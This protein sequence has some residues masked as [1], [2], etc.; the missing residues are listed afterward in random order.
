MT[1]EIAKKAEQK[2]NLRGWLTRPAVVQ[3]IRDALAGY[4]DAD[5]FLAQIVI[6]FQKPEIAACTPQSLFAAAHTCASLGLLPGLNQVAII[7]R[8]MGGHLVATVMP[9]WQGY[10]ALMMR[11]PDVKDIRATLVHRVDEYS[12]DS[13]TERLQHRYDPLSPSRVFRTT[14]DLF[15]GYLRIEY[16]DGRPVRYH[17]VHA[18]NIQKAMACADTKNVWTKWFEEQALKTLFRNGYARRVVPIDPLVTARMEATAK[19]DDEALGNNPDAIVVEANHKSIEDRR[20][21]PSSRASALASGMRAMEAE[22]PSVP[23]TTTEPEQDKDEPSV[24]PEKQTRKTTGKKK[25]A[26]HQDDEFGAPPLDHKGVLALKERIAS[27]ESGE[28]LGELAVE[29]G[30]I[31]MM[32]VQ[33]SDLEKALDARHAELT[34]N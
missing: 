13:E 31:E 20:T 26:D 7:P 24:E 8:K 19:A 30:Q 16:T 3:G 2:D 28:D 5:Q 21:S 29:I 32:G 22:Y 15:G 1:N 18:D 27:C 23:V 33:R 9:Q 6:H 12:Y 4:M 17:F 34:A 25:P 11:H 10:Q 14:D